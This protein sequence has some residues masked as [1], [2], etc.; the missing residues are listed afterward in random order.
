MSIPNRW[1]CV[2]VIILDFCPAR[3]KLPPYSS[4]LFHYFFFFFLFFLILFSF[5]FFSYCSYISTFYFFFFL[6]SIP[7]GLS[8]FFFPYYSSSWGYLYL[9]LSL[10]YFIIFLFLLYYYLI[11]L[12][13]IYYLLFTI[14]SNSQPLTITIYFQLSIPL[15]IVS[16][17]FSQRFPSKGA[18]SAGN[19]VP[20]HSRRDPIDKKLSIAWTTVLDWSMRYPLPLGF[21]GTCPPHPTLAAPSGRLAPPLLDG[22]AGPTLSRCHLPTSRAIHLTKPRK[23]PFGNPSLRVPLFKPTRNLRLFSG[24]LTYVTPL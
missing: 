6:F 5:I 10:L 15:A 23:V 8:T 11:I 9:L 14:Y 24:D 19:T 17:T 13:I 22:R 2:S 12:F 21:Q 18:G 4:T 16:L 3:G 1:G 7:W 20:T